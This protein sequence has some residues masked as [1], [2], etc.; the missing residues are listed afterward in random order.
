MGSG[1][2]TAMPVLSASALPTKMDAINHAVSVRFGP[3]GIGT[4]DSSM[5]MTVIA[6]LGHSPKA[7]AVG[8]DAPRL[9]EKLSPRRCRL[10][11]EAIHAAI[12]SDR[13][14]APSRHGRLD[15]TVAPVQ[16]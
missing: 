1:V 5:Y 16:T 14:Q 8:G 9:A 10:A 7:I 15:L 11:Y 12:K 4:L 13:L 6:A 3:F 2:D